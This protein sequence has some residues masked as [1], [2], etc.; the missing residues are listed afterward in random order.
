MAAGVQQVAIGPFTGGLNTFSDPTAVPDNAL[1]ECLNMDLDLDGS[2]VSRPPIVDR[3]INFTLGATGNI[4]ILGY[5][6]SAAGSPYLLASDGD[7]K[8]Y[9]FNG[10]TWELI[11]DTFAASAMVQFD[12]KAWMTAPVGS[13]NPGGWWTPTDGFNAEANM[14]KGSVIQSFK[15]RL[16]IAAGEEA[17]ANGTRMYFSKILGQVD[18]WAASN[19]FIDIGVGDGQNIIA[20]LVYYDSL[21]VFRTNSIYRFAYSS[22]PAA[23]DVSLTVPGIGLATRHSVTAMENYVYFMYE[24]R[25]YEFLN[26]RA[27]EINVAV[28]FE[29]L[30]LSGT[31]LPKA[32]SYFSNRIIFS[33]YDT[34]YIFSLRTRTWSRWRSTVHGGIGKFYE[35]LAAS[36][37]E[38]TAICH[39][40]RIVPAGA[41]RE[42]NTLHITD[43]ITLESEAFSCVAQTKNFNYDAPS[44][45]KRLMWWGVDAIFKT[46]VDA[47]AFP[48]SFVQTVTWGQLKDTTWGAVKSFTWSQPFSA[49]ISAETIRDTAGTGS[50]RKFVKFNK[51]LRF[52]QIYFKVSFDTDGSINSAPVRL[53]NLMTYVKAGQRVSKAIT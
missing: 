8:T 15:S 27:N 19:D 4:N 17:S 34:M 35:N 14:P 3:G 18:F 30:D 50:M 53:F 2:L 37:A 49:T 11:T 41:T 32:V 31:Y 45:Y 16:W 10:T 25:A 24:D 22:D 36:D 46:R 40:N 39:S 42:A 44:V 5:Y 6:T 51:S 7:T 21:L 13:T 48:I 12:N 29:A 28:P 26:G 20:V 47:I 9:F 1:V 52:R 33:Y 23:G 43:A 38:P